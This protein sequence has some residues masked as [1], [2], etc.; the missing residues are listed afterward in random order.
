LPVREAPAAIWSAL[1]AELH[2]TRPAAAGSPVLRWAFACVVVVGVGAGAYWW[3][4]AH[5]P[6]PWEVSIGAEQVARRLPEGGWV[7][8]GTSGARVIVGTIGAVD[9]GPD[10]RVRLGT[11]RESQYRLAL[12]RGTISA[13]ID[14]PPR[15]FVV[16]TPVSSV[17]D[18]GCAYTVHVDADGG[19][20]LRM[21][22]GW[23][24]LEWEGRETLVPAGAVSRTR[25]HRG[26]GLPYFADASSALKQAA[27]AFSAGSGGIDAVDAMLRQA[28]ARDT[29]TLWHLLSRVPADERER[30]YQRIEQLVP[31]PQGVAREDVLRLDSTALRKWREE[32]AWKW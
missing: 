15:I 21:T 13:T 10:T 1:E 12:A 9:V 6:R 19:S 24:A 28:R 18:L 32:M 23:A 20:E 26:P 8:T 22:Q 7:E 3:Q 11:A 29:L 31:P 30:V 4:R 2:A 25:P 27:D 5:E 16:D 14:A 17:V